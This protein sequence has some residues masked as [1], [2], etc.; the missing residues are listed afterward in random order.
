[1]RVSSSTYY[2]YKRRVRELGE[3]GLKDRVPRALEKLGRVSLE[4]QQKILLIAKEFPSYGPKRISYELSK[5]QFGGFSVPPSKIYQSLKRLNLA[6]KEQRREFALDG[7]KK[8]M[9]L[10]T[11]K[12]QEQKH[13]IEGDL[14]EQAVVVGSESEE[15]VAVGLAPGLDH[16]EVHSGTQPT[17][18]GE[19]ES[20]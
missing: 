5:P 11:D 2:K 12:S 18:V 17:T 15:P 10:D 6:T 3:E 16:E 8:I 1:M 19:E 20:K 13:E 9:N 4:V 14:V 7:T